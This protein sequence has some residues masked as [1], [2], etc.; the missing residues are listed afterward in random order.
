MEYN[1]WTITWKFYNLR[2]IL[3]LP[4]ASTSNSSASSGYSTS[5][6]YYI[7]CPPDFL[8]DP[9][10]SLH[11]ISP[12]L[13]TQML[14]WPSHLHLTVFQLFYTHQPIFSSCELGPLTHH[15][16]AATPL[17]STMPPPNCPLPHLT[18]LHTT[19]FQGLQE[20]TQTVLLSRGWHSSRRDWRYMLGKRLMRRRR[21]QQS[22]WRGR[23]WLLGEVRWALWEGGFSAETRWGEE[24]N[25]AGV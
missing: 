18:S 19:L 14:S 7:W 16:P 4:S 22:K 15:S 12:V 20:A 5:R 10:P 21:I 13:L 25:P 17:S 8:S 23:G 24:V 2:D 11:L 1:C 3:T 9:D 6:I